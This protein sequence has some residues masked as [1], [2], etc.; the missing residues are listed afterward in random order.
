MFSGRFRGEGS[1]DFGR[2]SA[3]CGDEEPKRT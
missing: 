2:A 3:H 1:S